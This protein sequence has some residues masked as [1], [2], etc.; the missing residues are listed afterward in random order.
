[1]NR[2]L[3]ALMTAL[4]VI[5]GLFTPLAPQA[6]APQAVRADTSSIT[7]DGLRDVD[8]VQ[9]ASDPAGDLGDP[10]GWTGTQWTDLTAL[11]VAVDATTLYVY[12]DLP[13]YTQSG[14]SGQIGLVLDVDNMPMSGGNVDP[15][16]NAITFSYD[17]V[18]GAATSAVVL[19][20]YVIRGN[21]AG[22]GGD[23][24]GWTELRAWNGSDWTGGG[25]NW[26]GIS[27]GGQVGTH[28][29][30]S[31]TNGVEFAIPLTD[32]GNVDPAAVHLQLFATQSGGAK[33]AYDT[34]PSDS[35]SAG[36]DDAT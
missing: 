25:T 3:F 24:K 1:M 18:D 31:D 14:S 7:L 9:I 29:A 11:Y 12:A 23:D 36:W 22:M 6:V 21:I 2:K 10:G 30:Y 28:V 17:T 15:W 27:G 16:A 34:V 35:Q 33:G 19:P 26:G 8:Y 13:S 5:A 4:A 20:D 32:I